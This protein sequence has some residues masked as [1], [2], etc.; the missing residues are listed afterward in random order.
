MQQY[1]KKKKNPKHSTLDILVILSA[2]LRIEKTLIGTTPVIPS[3]C[4]IY[5]NNS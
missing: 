4:V 3:F 1:E 2:N 5:L